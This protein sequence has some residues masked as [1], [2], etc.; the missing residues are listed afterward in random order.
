[1]VEKH[2]GIGHVPSAVW[3]QRDERKEPS[4]FLLIQSGTSSYGVVPPTIRL[5]C[6][7]GS[8]TGAPKLISMVTLYPIK[9]IIQMTHQTLLLPPLPQ[10]HPT[11]HT[12]VIIFFTSAQEEAAPSETSHAVM[13]SHQ[14]YGPH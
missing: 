2:E 11:T 6:S 13:T 5:T 10:P 7:A 14:G 3:K 9:L 12:N 8:L 1:M 4:C